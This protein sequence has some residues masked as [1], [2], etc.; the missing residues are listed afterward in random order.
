MGIETRNCKR[1]DGK[2]TLFTQ[3]FTSLEGKAY[4]DSTRKCYACDGA[5]VFAAP[6]LKSL[7]DAV[8]T[9]RGATNGKRRFRAS[10][11][12]NLVHYKS[13]DDRRGYYVWR[14]AR[15]HGGK[16]VT[17][18]IMAMTAISGDPFER[19]LDAFASLIAKACFGTDMAA[20]S[21]WG[22]LLGNVRPQDIPADLPMSAYEGGPVA[23]ENKPQE[24]ALELV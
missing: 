20:A 1:C 17:M 8:T 11:P 13:R 21:R 5:G 16:D 22:Q 7:L 2:R 10:C 19:E 12:K 14:L 15:F 23:D 6:D 4:P 9:A 18:P 3:G 24:E